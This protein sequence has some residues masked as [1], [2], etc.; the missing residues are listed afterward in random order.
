MT[1]ADQ[2]TPSADTNVTDRRGI[3]ADQL[4]PLVYDEL[5]RLASYYLSKERADHTLQPTALVHEAF[6]KLTGNADFEWRDATHFRAVAANAM[7]QILVDHAKRRRADK[8]GGNWMRITL[9]EVVSPDDRC[10][11]DLL[12]LDEAM[13][14]LAKLDPRKSRVVE[15][16]FFGGLT[17]DEAA[18]A[19]SISPKTAEAD[20]YMA[21][22]WLRRELSKAS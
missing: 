13:E 2:P 19:L 17:C 9:D 3:A 8:R 4:L 6:L 7:R 1:N 20:W 16:R 5:R 14:G 18:A 12:T 21:R 11:V 15:L 10:D 22:A